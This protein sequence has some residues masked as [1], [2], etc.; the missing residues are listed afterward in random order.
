MTRETIIN[1]AQSIS[2][3]FLKQI[4]QSSIQHPVFFI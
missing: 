3:F 4:N 2:F 1:P